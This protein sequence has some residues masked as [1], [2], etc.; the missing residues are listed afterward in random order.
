VQ[1]CSDPV[2][3]QRLSECGRAHALAKWGVVS[4]SRQL[5]EVIDILRGLPPKTLTRRRRMAARMLDRY[6]RWAGHV[7]RVRS[8]LTWYGRQAG[9]RLR[10]R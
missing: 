8:V 2:L 7:G 6:V 1:L 5:A 9:R 4:V 3:H 10:G